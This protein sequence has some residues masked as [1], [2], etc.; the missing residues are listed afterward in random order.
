[1]TLDATPFKPA[2]VY[3]IYIA[4]TPERVWQALT[5]PEFTRLFFFGRTIEISPHEAI[6]EMQGK[7]NR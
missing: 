3:T 7:N 1:M 6:Q 2:I 5:S 4:A